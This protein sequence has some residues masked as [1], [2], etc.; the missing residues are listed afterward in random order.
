MCRMEL[1]NKTPIGPVL[2]RLREALGIC[3]I[4]LDEKKIRMGNAM[5]LSV[6]L[7]EWRQCSSHYRQLLHRNG[8]KLLFL[9]KSNCSCWWHGS[10][11]TLFWIIT[12]C[13]GRTRFL[14]LRQMDCSAV[15]FKP[16]HYG[17]DTHLGMWEGGTETL[18]VF[19]HQCKET[20]GNILSLATFLKR[21]NKPLKL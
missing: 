14:M 3:G 12:M 1:S 10:T 8:R 17:L 2:S 5:K 18:D 7:L 20:R 4:K 16:E 21:T 11:K 6:H 13:L 9:N 19:K 15:L